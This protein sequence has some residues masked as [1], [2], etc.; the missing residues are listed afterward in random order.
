MKKIKLT[1]VSLCISALMGAIPLLSAPVHADDLNAKGL[2]GSYI[3]EYEQMHDVSSGYYL[4]ENGTATETTSV[5]PAVTAKKYVAD[6]ADLL[7]KSE[8][9]ALNSKLEKISDELN[10]DVAVVTVNSTGS[11]TATEYAD[12]Y[13]D[14]NGYGR[15]SN[16]DGALF[17]VSISDRKWAIS[18]KGYGISAINKDALNYMEDEIIPIL[19]D[20][21]YS[22]AF[23][24]FADL[25]YD[26]VK[27]AKKGNSFTEPK[28]S[29]DVLMNLIIA[30]SIG[31][32][33]SM[34]IILSYKKKLKPVK[35]ETEAK[36]YIVP[37]SFNIRRSDDYFLYF[38]ITKIPIPKN[39]SDSDSHTSSSGS[40]HGGSSGSF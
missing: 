33:I 32:F 27:D 35:F 18:T 39:D 26:I 16:G 11:K 19:K 29:K 25:T 17:L 1:V 2:N 37:G 15:G 13:F 38:N 6:D 28:K 3:G 23:N 9:E 22:D 12:D 21:N 31:A 30:F 34:I 24:K 5:T 10:F 20:G 40:S 4:A 14:Y 8:E 7:D 36:A